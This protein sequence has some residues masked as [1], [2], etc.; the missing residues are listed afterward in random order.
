MSSSRAFSFSTTR[1]VPSTAGPSSSE[2]MRRAIEPECWGRS[3]T[4]RS[5]ATTKQAMEDFMS[6]APRPN[7]LPSRTVGTNGSERH[8]ASGP[9]GTT[10]VWPAK[11]TTGCAPPRRAQRLVTSPNFID[12]QRKPAFCRRA[13]MRSWQPPSSGVIDRRSMSCLVSSS[14]PPSG[15]HV[16]LEVVEGVVGRGLVAGLL[17]AAGGLRFR[18]R[19]LPADLASGGLVDEPKHVGGRIGVRHRL[20]LADLAFHKELEER[21]LEG[22]RA[23]RHAL[24]ERVLDLVDLAFFDQLGDMARIE[25]HFHRRDARARLRAHQ[26]LRN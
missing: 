1:T 12:S 20:F 4:K 23:G 11:Q 13:A 8:S 24:F 25:Q 5:A 16:D 14:A 19:R 22:L 17:A 6:A 26:A 7:S 18:R 3:A 9:V 15:I 10:S 2:V 21:L